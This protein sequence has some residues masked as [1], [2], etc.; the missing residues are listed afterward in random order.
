MLKWERDAKEKGPYKQGVF[1]IGFQ[2]AQCGEWE[3]EWK[4]VILPWLQEAVLSNLNNYCLVSAGT[5]QRN[6]KYAQS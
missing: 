4:P 6:R 2:L 5:L 3:R 1:S